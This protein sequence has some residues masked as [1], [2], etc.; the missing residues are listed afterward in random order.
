MGLTYEVR[1]EILLSKA[2]QDASARTHSLEPSMQLVRSVTLS[3]LVRGSLVVS[4]NDVVGREWL[5]W[6]PQ[7]HSTYCSLW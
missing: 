7:A 5:P 2:A 6:K 1:L 3:A 4:S